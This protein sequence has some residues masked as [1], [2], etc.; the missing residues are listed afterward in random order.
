[1]ASIEARL[2]F[3]DLIKAKQFEDVNLNMIKNKVVCGEAQESTLDIGCIT[4]VKGHV[5]LPM[6]MI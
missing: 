3:L 4:R 1:M 5:Y 2:T 6:L